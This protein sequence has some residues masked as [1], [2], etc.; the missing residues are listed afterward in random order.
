MIFVMKNRSLVHYS[1]RLTEMANAFIAQELKSRGIEDIAPCHGDI[2]IQLYKND[3]ALVTELARRAR[4]TKSTMS[5]MVDKLEKLGYV[6]K[7][8]NPED[9]RAIG[10]Y[11]TDKG[12]ALHPTFESI[13]ESL[14]AKV[15]SPLSEEEADQLEALMQK[16]L[17][18]F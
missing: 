1:G 8:R 18:N 17:N 11:L 15:F 4:R 6:R 2:L 5:V 14:N 16:V 7:M 3:G 13:S 12:L 10:V 9:N